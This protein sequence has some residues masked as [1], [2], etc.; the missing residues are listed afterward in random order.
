MV[1]VGPDDSSLYGFQFSS[2]LA[3]SRNGRYFK[4]P[5]DALGNGRGSIL[6]QNKRLS[7]ESI[8]Y[9]ESVQQEGESIGIHEVESLSVDSFGFTSD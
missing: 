2:S 6:L 3:V 1:I 9:E 7:P 8:L 4:Y 5:N